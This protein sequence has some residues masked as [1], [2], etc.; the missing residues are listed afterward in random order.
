MTQKTLAAYYAAEYRESVQGSAEPTD[1]DL[2]MQTARAEHLLDFSSQ[3]L[4]NVNKCL[5]VGSST[6]LLLEAFRNKYGCEGFGIEPGEAYANFSRDRGF[7]VVS[8]IQDLD[9]RH[10]HTFDLVTMSHTLEHIP[11]PVD[12]LVALRKSWLI[13]SGYLL[14]EVPNLYGHHALERAHLIAFSEATLRE[15]IRQAGYN[16]LKVK[17]HGFPRSRLIPLY[18][19]LL[20]RGRESIPP[21]QKMSSRSTGVR[22]RRNLGMR[23]RWI[24]SKL[25]PRWAWLPWPEISEE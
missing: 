24:A 6:G 1:K 17:V 4:T 21:V 5:D 12:Y 16:V 18:I 8:D 7:Q 10:E 11:G 9:G 23:W 3:V 19:T 14:L 2:R 20:A 15:T 13:P 22:T 25:A